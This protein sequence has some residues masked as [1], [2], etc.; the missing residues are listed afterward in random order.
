MVNQRDT[1]Y[2][3]LRGVAIIMVIGIHTYVDGL[4]HLN[5]FFRQFLNC[6]VPIFLAISGYFIGQKS[7]DAKGSY[8]KFLGKQIPRVYLPMLYWS[9]PW[10]LLTIK[11]G[12][13]PWLIFL[14][15]FAGEMSI[16]YFI[17]LIIQYYILTPAIQKANIKI[18]G[19]F[20][21]IDD[22]RNFILRLYTKN[23]RNEALLSAVRLSLPR[24][25][26]LL[27]HGSSKSTAHKATFPNS[28]TSSI[29]SH[30]N[31]PVSHSDCMVT[32]K[33]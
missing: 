9:I 14:K 17:I 19:V 30:R 27:C 16:F 4:M 23:T 33:L 15:I 2:D 32:Y 13:D 29:R 21:N 18:G 3:F 28:K 24:V 22:N 5:L 6:A 8:T 7:F 26:G 1:Y 20:S 12:S 31:S 10:A 11:T 25:D